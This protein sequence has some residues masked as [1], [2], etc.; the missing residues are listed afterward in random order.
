MFALQ[1]SNDMCFKGL[2]TS[3]DCLQMVYISSGCDFVSFFHGYGKK[4][5]FD[6][7]RQNA[8]FISSDLSICD[9]DNIQGLCAF[10][11]HIL[12]VYFSKH[13]TAFQP[14][15]S[16]KEMYDKTICESALDKHVTLIK[17]FRE[18]MWERVWS[19]VEMFP[20]AE[21][22]KLHWLRCCWNMPTNLNQAVDDPD[23]DLEDSEQEEDISYESDSE[24]DINEFAA[25]TSGNTSTAYINYWDTFENYIFALPTD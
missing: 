21:A 2:S 20:N 13:R 16:V 9:E 19:E 22:L 23:S 12:C 3:V 11:R 15:S 1:M 17:D 5:F 7:F 18:R 6:I 25:D 24:T 10:F 8:D 4:T 14:A